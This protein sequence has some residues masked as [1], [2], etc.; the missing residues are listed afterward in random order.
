MG[1]GEVHLLDFYIFLFTIELEGQ[2]VFF[3]PQL[4]K[5][6]WVFLRGSSFVKNLPCPQTP[7]P[8]GYQMVHP[9]NKCIRIVV[10]L[11]GYIACCNIPPDLLVVVLI[12]IFVGV[13]SRD[14]LL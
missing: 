6:F 14:I 7:T 4:G 3:T 8:S 10:K 9:Y 2:G 1:L 12:N 5:V 13:S 11:F